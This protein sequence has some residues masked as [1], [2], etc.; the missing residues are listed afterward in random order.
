MYNKQNAVT[1]IYK[2][3]SVM[4]ASPG[5]L[6]LMLYNACIKDIKV[7]IECIK[8]KKYEKANN[9]LKKAQD[10]IRELSHTLDMRYPISAN[11]KEL[12]DFIYGRL[13]QGNMR[14]DVKP[15]EEALHFVQE[16][17]ATWFQVIKTVEREKS[18]NV[19]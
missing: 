15:L 11:M 7:G 14:K 1:D 4:T 12:Y 13:V 17:R 6:T 18:R 10:I 8:Q 5:E 2:R 3:Q 9:Y 19:V 16:F